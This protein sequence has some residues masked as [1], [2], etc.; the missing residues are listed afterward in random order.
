MGVWVFALLALV[1]LTGA[2]VTVFVDEHEFGLA[3]RAA[4]QLIIKILQ[5]AQFLAL[6][7]EKLFATPAFEFFLNQKI[8]KTVFS[9]NP[10]V[11]D[12]F[13]RLD[14]VDV[15]A[16]IKNYTEKEF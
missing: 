10:K 4:E 15:F 12:T 8:N 13:A 2:S 5:R 3:C 1:H 6:G 14:D 16:S 11:L 7:G 9:A